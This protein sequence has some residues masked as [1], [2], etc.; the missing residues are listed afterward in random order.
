MRSHPGHGVQRRDVQVDLVDRQPGKQHG[1]VRRTYTKPE[2]QRD[3]GHDA[4][5]TGV[6]VDGVKSWNQAIHKMITYTIT[7]CSVYIL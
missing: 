1:R 2:K 4:H 5:G 3:P 7:L 6:G